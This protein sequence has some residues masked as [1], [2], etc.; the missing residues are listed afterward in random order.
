MPDRV[1]ALEMHTLFRIPV[2]A[3]L[4]LSSLVYAQH[5]N[6][7]SRIVRGVTMYYDE[8]PIWEPLVRFHRPRGRP[9]SGQDRDPRGVGSAVR[10]GVSAISP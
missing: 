1:Y 7:C 6:V 10:A 9:D 4:R 8:M 2:G 5:T 3:G